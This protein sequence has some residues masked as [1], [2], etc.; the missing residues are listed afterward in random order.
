MGILVLFFIFVL[1]FNYIFGDHHSFPEEAQQT[2]K[3]FCPILVALLSQRSV[4]CQP[5]VLA[6]D[7]QDCE[8]TPL[9]GRSA[10]S[11]YQ[12]QGV[13]GNQHSLAMQILRQ[14]RQN[15][16]KS[17]RKVRHAMA[18][19]LG[20]DLCPSHQVETGFSL[21]LHR[22][23]SSSTNSILG[24]H[25]EDFWAR[26]WRFCN[27]SPV[28]HWPFAIPLPPLDNAF[29]LYD[30][31]L[32]PEPFPSEAQ[33]RLVEEPFLQREH[34][35]AVTAFDTVPGHGLQAEPAAIQELYMHWLAHFAAIE[36]VEGQA[37][38]TL[39]VSTWYL[40][41]PRQ[42]SCD[43]SRAVQL[44]QNF[45]SWTREIVEVWSD[46]IDPLWPVQFLLVRP[47]PPATLL[48]RQ[49]QQH[50]IVAQRL[51][52][53][54]FA[55]RFS[56]LTVDNVIEPLRHVARFAPHQVSKPQVIGFAG[57]GD[58][59]YPEQSSLQLLQLPQGTQGCLTAG[60]VAHTE[61]PLSI[62]WDTARSPPCRR[63]RWTITSPCWFC[64]STPSQHCHQ[65]LSTWIS[66]KL[67]PRPWHPGH[68][69]WCVFHSLPHSASCSYRFPPVYRWVKSTSRSSWNWHCPVAWVQWWT[70]F[71]WSPEQSHSAWRT[72]RT[73]WEWCG[74]LGHPLGHPAEQLR[75][76][77]F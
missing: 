56:I 37:D 39:E 10:P 67:A 62:S 38:P 50:I 1:Y 17:L 53:D 72:C 24:F 71:W 48:Q 43:E 68:H 47:L 77:S 58:E 31:K 29:F 54:G 12:D 4:P 70:C 45:A 64:S 8:V 13:R 16:C 66:A 52:D 32:C 25:A 14:A 55:N 65:W 22:L 2:E 28:W 3:G 23:E 60:P 18:S 26:W 74:H 59:C 63:H 75:L 27:V 57:Q 19:M 15:G 6:E 20:H 7:L 9:E 40:D 46:L 33:D 61:R 49:R 44:R 21:D 34:H 5:P 35:Y 41:M 11:S 69:T 73:W 42:L 36:A 51:P 30:D 76:A